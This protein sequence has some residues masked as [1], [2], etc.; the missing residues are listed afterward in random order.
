MVYAPSVV[1]ASVAEMPHYLL[2]DNVRPNSTE[3]QND[4]RVDRVA[5]TCS[6]HPPD[7]S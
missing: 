5:E 3:R 2:L 6:R 1:K 4:L 7:I